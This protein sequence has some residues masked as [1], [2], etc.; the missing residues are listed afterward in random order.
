MSDLQVIQYLMKIITDN[1]Q[2]KEDNRALF[3]EF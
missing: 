2:Q 3:L 1:E